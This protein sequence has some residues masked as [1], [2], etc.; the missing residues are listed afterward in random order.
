MLVVDLALLVIATAGS[1]I[2]IDAFESRS[3]AGEAR[4]DFFGHE[5]T[6]PLRR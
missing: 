5:R 6:L 4:H 1:V 3:G 2:G